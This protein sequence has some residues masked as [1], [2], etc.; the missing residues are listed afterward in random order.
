MEI[1][2]YKKTEIQNSYVDFKA[3][4]D[5]VVERVEEEFVQIGYYLKIARDTHVLQESGY[6]S[7]T[8]FAAAEYGLDKSAVSRFIAINDRFAED[9][10]SDRLKDQYRGMGRAKLSVML[11]LPE[12]I[13]EELT[14]DYSKSDIQKIKDEVE[15]E[16][17]VTDLEV[18]MEQQDFDTELLDNNLKRA[19]YQL[20]HDIPELHRKIWN[21]WQIWNGWQQTKRPELPREIMDILAPAGEGMHSVRVAGIGRLMITLHGADQDI[22]LINVRSGEKEKY[23]WDDMMEAIGLLME[24]DTP[25]ESWAKTYGENSSVAPV[26]LDPKSKVTKAA[27]PKPGSQGAE[28]NI[29]ENEEREEMR[30]EEAEQ[31]AGVPEE[32]GPEQLPHGT[33]KGEGI[34]WK[35]PEEK[36]EFREELPKK[37]AEYRVPIGSNLLKDIRS[38][39]RFLILRTKDPF[40]V[41]NIIHLFGQKNGE[42][43]GI[44]I[45]IQITHLIKDHGGLV[46]GYVAFQFEVIPAAPGQIPGQMEI[47]DVAK[48]E[49]VEPESGEETD[50]EAGVHGEGAKSNT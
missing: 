23:S 29:P 15:E 18:M 47:G 48:E 34:S 41:E 31:T 6:K 10:Y 27:E 43:T 39:Q 22:A 1:L 14:P 19:M 45:D 28:K 17:K 33:S 11:L 44:E 46:P 20:G 24:G 4:M 16:K 42:E 30:Q 32:I 3:S 26:Q 12:E 2:N 25:E 13:T 9:G 38:G 40:C 49:G 21:V 5:A 37:D 50:A 8:D 36:K 35:E 7:V